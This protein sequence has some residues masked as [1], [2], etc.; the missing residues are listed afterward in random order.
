MRWMDGWMDGSFLFLFLIGVWE[1]GRDGDKWV[2]HTYGKLLI[3]GA[4]RGK[5][6][7]DKRSGKGNK[8]GAAASDLRNAKARHV[9]YTAFWWGKKA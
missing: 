4:I 9:M 1:R 8:D 5:V 2:I 6:K 7:A 3:V